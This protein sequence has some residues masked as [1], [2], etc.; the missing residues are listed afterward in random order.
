[1]I[2]AASHLSKVYND[3]VFNHILRNADI[4]PAHKKD[5]TTKKDNY[6]TISILPSVSKVPKTNVQP[7]LLIH[8]QIPLTLSVAFGRIIVRNNA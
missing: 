8:V 3:P 2:S 4:S 5:E 1:M 6:R 7:N